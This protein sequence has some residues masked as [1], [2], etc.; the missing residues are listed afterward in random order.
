[1]KKLNIL[2]GIAAPLYCFLVS[3][4]MLCTEYSEKYSDIQN[5]LLIAL[6]A[7]PGMMLA[8]ILIRN[9][10][11]EF[12]QSFGTCF[13]TSVFG[14]IGIALLHRAITGSDELPLGDGILLATM[15]IS[16]ITSC[17]AGTVISGIISLIRQKKII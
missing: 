17:I 5:F 4:L 14:F 9:S 7:L 2:I 8:F 12:F 3:T 15:L 13:L 6:P 16:Y 10:L 1:M 11:K